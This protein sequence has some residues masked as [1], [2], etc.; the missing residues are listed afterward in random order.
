M[1]DPALPRSDFY[2]F[3]LREQMNDYSKTSGYHISE[4]CLYLGS[5]CNYDDCNIG[6]I[7]PDFRSNHLSNSF[8]RFY[9]RHVTLLRGTVKL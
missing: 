3:P 1:E 6:G 9:D 4:P 5:C 2:R 7:V 8:K